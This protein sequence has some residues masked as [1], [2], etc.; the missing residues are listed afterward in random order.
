MKGN[1]LV[2]VVIATYNMGKYL[3]EAVESVR[4]QSWNTLEIIIVDDGSTD[5]TA[6][7]AA[8]WESDPRVRYV[9]Q[10]NQGQTVAKNH[11]IALAQGSFIAFLD[12]DDRWKPYK[13][14]HQMPLFPANPAI[15]V[16]Y[17]DAVFIDENGRETGRREISHPHGRVTSQLLD[18]NFVYFGSTVVSRQALE[19]L[20]AFD[21]S[22]P[23]SIDYDLW[24]R[25][26]TAYEFG[27][28][29]EPLL[30]YRI[31][32]GQMSHKMLART[33]CVLRILDKFEREHPACAKRRELQRARATT[34]VSR[35]YARMTAGEG[36]LAALPEIV[37]ALGQQ[38]SYP[39][40]WKDLVKI[41][42]GR[43]G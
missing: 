43:T 25:L 32:G 27:Y 13:L 40:I 23:M 7:V 4:S 24:L 34:Y 42:I 22:L 29:D 1:P 17:S 38:A 10:E 12:G 20:G 5:D 26:S 39:R 31:W 9:R 15:G 30:E 18:D 8:R 35:A 36:R 41:L 14:E 3:P 6:T 21:E 2:S 33:D 16:V 19:A 37:R 28:V 11:G